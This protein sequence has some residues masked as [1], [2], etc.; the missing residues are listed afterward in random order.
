MSHY[1]IA[2]IEEIR[3]ADDVVIVYLKDIQKPLEG[4]YIEFDH[5]NG[6]FILYSYR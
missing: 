3:A 5:A 1:K 4:D 2:D 6:E